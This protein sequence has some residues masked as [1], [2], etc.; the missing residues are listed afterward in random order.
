[1]TSSKKM[2]GA[3][4]SQIVTVQGKETDWDGRQA[5]SGS[6]GVQQ[7][8]KQRLTERDAAGQIGSVA[9]EKVVHR[10]KNVQATGYSMYTKFS[11][12]QRGYC[13]T[14]PPLQ[15]HVHWPV[16]ACLR[17]GCLYCP[18]TSQR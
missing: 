13:H 17:V 3:N 12:R 10:G 16:S 11:Q 7:T 4:K 18:C 15:R 5:G 1:M 2:E 9:G 14:T 6:D 8:S